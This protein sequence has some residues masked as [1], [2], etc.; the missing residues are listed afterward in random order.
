[1]LS[2]SNSM[3]NSFVLKI[4]TSKVFAI[5]ILQIFFA[6]PAPSKPF[7]GMGGGGYLKKTK[8]VQKPSSSGAPE[9]D[10]PCELFPE[11]IHR[12][13]NRRWPLVVS[14]FPEGCTLHRNLGPIGLAND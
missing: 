1:M 14:Q 10:A 13:E 7:K 2:E 4:L 3:R 5:K 9:N 8:S 12:R 11:E 6:N